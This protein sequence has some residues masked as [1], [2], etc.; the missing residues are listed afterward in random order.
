MIY[1]LLDEQQTVN[2]EIIT[3]TIEKVT[4]IEYC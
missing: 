2:I 3:L 1:I 4:L